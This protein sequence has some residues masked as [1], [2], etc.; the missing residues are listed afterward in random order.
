MKEITAA[1]RKKA[2][3]YKNQ[4]AK[5]KVINYK[6]NDKVVCYR[7]TKAKGLSFKAQDQ[8]SGPWIIEKIQNGHY[9]CRKGTKTCRVPY[10]HINKYTPRIPPSDNPTFEEPMEILERE[11]LKPGDMVLVGDHDPNEPGNCMFHM[12]KYIIGKDGP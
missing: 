11:D 8:W 12:A 9:H 7:P 10:A 2:V 6:V 4:Q 1:E 3:E 5:L